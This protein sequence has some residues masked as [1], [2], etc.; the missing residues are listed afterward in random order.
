M[1]EKLQQFEDELRA[2]HAALT[3]AFETTQVTAE[4]EWAR[5]MAAS[6]ALTTFRAKYGRVLKAL[7]AKAVT[8]ET[9]E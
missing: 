7:D 3:Q 9:K 8:I 6:E 5:H 2:E 1:S 4:A